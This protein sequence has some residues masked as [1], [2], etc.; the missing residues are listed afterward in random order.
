MLSGCVHIADTQ[1]AKKRLI[2]LP[3][4]DNSR[5]IRDLEHL[6]NKGYADAVIILAE[7][8]TRIG[9]PVDLDKT[10]VAFKKMLSTSESYQKRYI[11]WLFNVA[12]ANPDYLNRARSTLW[13]RMESHRD[14]GPQ[15]IRLESNAGSNVNEQV[16]KIFA[17]YEQYDEPRIDDKIQ[18]LSELESLT[19]WI[20]TLRKLCKEQNNSSFYCLRSLVRH[21][22]KYSPN[23]LNELAEN[24]NTAYSAQNINANE[25]ISLVKLFAVQNEVIGDGSVYLASIAAKNAIDESDDVFLAFAEYEIGQKLVFNTAQLIERLQRISDTHA[26]ANVLLGRLYMEGR[27]SVEFP[28][29]SLKYLEK[30]LPNS[31]ASFYLGRLL[32]SGKLG[33]AQLQNAVDMFVQSARSGWFRSYRELIQL[34]INGDGIKPNLIY[35]HVFARTYEK[36]G[37]VLSDFNNQQLNEIPPTQEQEKVISQ[38]VEKELTAITVYEST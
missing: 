29:K 34:F 35:A 14:V 21:A 24:T 10:E 18:V 16:S 4:V 12:R 11:N 8:Y 15:I 27:R 33:E 23:E 2:E 3:T 7:Y 13:Q 17:I 1:E 36:L 22:K 38:L 25:L 6:S 28:Q 31:A 26:L 37:F 9:K 5:A 30:A 19:E 32:I 20:E